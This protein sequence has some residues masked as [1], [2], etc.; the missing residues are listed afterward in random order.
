MLKCSGIESK[1]YATKIWEACNKRG[2]G[3]ICFHRICFKRKT[4]NQGTLFTIEENA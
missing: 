4:Q 2:A 1:R 3:D